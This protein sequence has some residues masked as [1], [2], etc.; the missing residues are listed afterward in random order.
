MSTQARRS[1]HRFA[2]Q[3]A[4]LCGV[5]N[6]LSLRL[7]GFSQGTRFS[8]RNPKTHETNWQ[9][10]LE[11]ESER[12]SVCP[13]ERAADWWLV[14]EETPNP[15]HNRGNDGWMDGCLEKAKYTV[16]K[17][18]TQAKVN[19]WRKSCGN[20]LRDTR[21]THIQ[22]WSHNFKLFVVTKI[23]KPREFRF[24]QISASAKQKPEFKNSR[25]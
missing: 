25:E 16:N 14:R 7:R 11:R 15:A 6:V 18:F 8:R 21:S 12:L 9:L 20:C 19:I 2:V 24:F 5:C 1:R 10:Q 23:T 13:C 17:T 3:K 22:H 4:S